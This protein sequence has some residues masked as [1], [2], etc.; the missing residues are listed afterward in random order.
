MARHTPSSLALIAALALRMVPAALL[1]WPAHAQSPAPAAKVVVYRGALLID[2]TGAP[3]RSDRVIVTG[4]E[5]ITAVA[6][7]AGFSVPAGAE[8][9]DLRDRF[10]VPGFVNSH[11]HLAT[12]ADPRHARAYLRREL[13]SGVTA[14][15]DMAGD[16][17]LLAEL[18][19]EAEFNEIPA[20]DIY[21][22]ALMA[23]PEF[24]ADPRTHDAARGRIAGEV[25][26]MQALT[27]QT[28]LPLAVAAARGTGATALKL[29]ADLP[30]PLMR[31]VTAE[32]H[33][34]HLLV[35]AH[36][37]LFPA[38]PLDE[39]DA[40]VDV[41]SHAALLGYALEPTIPPLY[42]HGAMPLEVAPL[43]ERPD[44]RLT[45]LFADMRRHGTILDATL[46]PYD[47]GPGAQRS[48]GLADRLAALAYRAG[49]AISTG[50]DDDGDLARPSSPLLEEFALLVHRAGMRLPDLLTSATRIGARA[51]GQ[52][53]EMGTIEPGKL[54]DFV[55]LGKNPLADVDNLRSVDLTVKRGIRYPHRD[56]TPVTEAEA[57]GAP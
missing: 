28:D 25:P 10:V 2:G 50:T 3:P 20:P 36:A 48:Q 8:V 31:A 1:T 30:A 34:Q 46:Y 57:H 42:R 6:P 44:A 38:G 56:Y 54:A 37:T 26:W 52:E 24:F 27:P 11:V 4:G 39:V 15:R 21:Y 23:G 41:L 22:V 17:R 5:R 18:K 40:G 55:V 9:V 14:L 49:V 16:V 7:A 32:A 43:L 19:R 35:W 13:Y 33:R 29:Y 47:S 51:A 45:A 12:L 53:H